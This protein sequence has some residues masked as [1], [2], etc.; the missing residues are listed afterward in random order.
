MAGSIVDGLQRGIDSTAVGT[1]DGVGGVAGRDGHLGRAGHVAGG[2]AL[3]GGSE[4]AAVDHIT[5]GIV[6][7]C[8]ACGCNFISMLFYNYDQAIFDELKE[9]GIRPL[10]P[11]GNAKYK[12]D[13]SPL[14]ESCDC[15]ACKN[16]TKAYIR[17]LIVASETFGQRLLSI[18]NIRFLIKLTEDAREAIKNDKYKIIN[19]FINSL[20]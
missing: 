4:H 1:P 2:E 16:Y 19:N 20:G 14:D 15:Y 18:H 12:N 3:V 8:R 7:E 5:D 11:D 6:E 10:N 13:Y 9:A 17:H